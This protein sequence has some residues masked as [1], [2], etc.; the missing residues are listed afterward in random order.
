ML[1]AMKNFVA[2]IRALGTGFG[3]ILRSPKLLLLGALPALISTVL[4]LAGLG[5]LL[6]FSG[7]VTTWMTPFA[8]TW[9]EFWRGALRITAGIALVGGAA[10]LA[11]LSFLALTLAIGGPF[12]EYIAE[13]TE[14]RLGLDTRDDG[15]GW[16]RV[17]G[18]GVRDSLKLVAVSL[19]GAIVLFFLG[20]V[21]VA[22]QTVVPVLAALFGAWMVSR[23][24]VGL[25]FQ[26]RG[27]KLGDRHRALRRHRAT[28]LGFGLP[29][30]LL[31]LVPVAQLVVIP[32]AVVGGTL[33]AH[34]ALGPAG[35]AGPSHLQWQG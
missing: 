18:R 23:E 25:V 15:A 35:H 3:L 14:Q 1:A 21:P 28:V 33:L 13:Q 30:Y 20:F 6:Y 16:L 22:G 11:S 29:V 26:R 24:M 2:G 8:D 32:S 17:F 27:L 19:A 10:L 4:L 31:C 34:R 5:T 12:Y 9:P 7:E